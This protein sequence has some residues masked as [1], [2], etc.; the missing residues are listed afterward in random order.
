MNQQF[1][2]KNVFQFTLILLVNLTF[3][4]S[5]YSQKPQLIIPNQSHLYNGIENQC[6]I[7]V[8]DNK[9]YILKS[10]DTE[11]VIIKHIQDRE[12]NIDVKYNTSKTTSIVIG[13]KNKNRIDWIDT[14]SFEVKQMEQPRV[15]IDSLV[16]YKNDENHYSISLLPNK[17]KLFCSYGNNYLD[18]QKNYKILKFRLLLLTKDK[19]LFELNSNSDSLTNKQLSIIK[20]KIQPN[21][22][23]LFDGIYVTNKNNN[24]I[25]LNPLVLN[26]QETEKYNR[27]FNCDYLVQGYVRRNGKLYNYNTNQLNLFYQVSDTLIKDSIWK[28]STIDRSKGEF[29]CNQIDSFSNN[30][31]IKSYFLNY[32]KLSE[33][34]YLNDSM[35]EMRN[36]YENGVLHQKGMVLLETDFRKYTYDSYYL[37]HCYEDWCCSPSDFIQDT[38]Y[39]NHL[40]DMESTTFPI[41]N[42]KIYGKNGKLLIDMNFTTKEIEESYLNRRKYFQIIPKGD[43]LIY[44]ESGHLINTIKY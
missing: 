17:I 14:V 38:I 25:L 8:F 35:A 22:I 11:R 4:T 28:F 44:N 7:K 36:Y 19:G 31:K 42:W 33:V 2:S 20:S 29:V 30:K 43:C 26:Y 5:A 1:N 39:S 16:F 40:E 32:K 6:F 13:L 21:S 15:F 34:E 37:E 9:Q 12:Y 18:E 23:L 27:Q 10:L 24:T 3:I 41:G